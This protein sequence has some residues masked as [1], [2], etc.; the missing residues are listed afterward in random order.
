MPPPIQTAQQQSEENQ[1]HA[2]SGEFAKIHFETEPFD[3]ENAFVILQQQ[4]VHCHRKINT[5]NACHNIPRGENTKG[6][7][8]TLYN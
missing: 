8:A 5:Q 3:R 2:M 4:H 7:L 6:I 1:Y